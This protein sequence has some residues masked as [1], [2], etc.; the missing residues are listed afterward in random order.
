MVK[1]KKT[2]VR[3]TTRG[4][5]HSHRGKEWYQEMAIQYKVKNM[6]CSKMLN[7]RWPC[8][9][10]QTNLEIILKREKE[11]VPQR[12]AVLALKVVNLEA[13]RDQIWKKQSLHLETKV[14]H[15]VFWIIC[16]LVHSISIIQVLAA[17]LKGCKGQICSCTHKWLNSKLKNK[18]SWP[19]LTN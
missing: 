11:K 7:L 1:D 19:K 12:K 2:L 14:S 16:S 3:I 18:I 10:N 4:I 8:R 5:N 6:K 13:R 9:I 15:L 17:I